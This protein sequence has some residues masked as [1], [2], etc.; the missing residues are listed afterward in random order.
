[1][2]LQLSFILTHIWIIPAL[3]LCAFLINVLFFR[4]SFKKFSGITALLFVGISACLSLLV[5]YDFYALRIN[6]VERLSFVPLEYKWLSYHPNMVAKMGII[7][8]P[9]SVMMLVVVTSISFLVHLFSLG[10]MKDDE[11]Y[12]RYFTYLPFF[13]FNM[14]GLILA[15]NIIQMFVFWELVG[16]SSFLL[17]GY[18]Y[19][20][21]SAVYA[22]KKAFIVTRF[23]DLGFLL[24]IL[25]LS[26]LGM[27][28][29]ILLNQSTLDQ[30]VSVFDFG[31]I[32]SSEFHSLFNSL[33]SGFFGVSELGFALILIFIGAAGKSAM[34]PLHI[35]LPDAM[36]GPTP[37]SAL[38]HAATMVVA[39]VYLVAR[40]FPAFSAANEALDLVG[41][42]GAITS[43]F[44]AI[45]ACTQVDLKRVLA[46]STL[47][48]LGYLMMGLGMATVESSL[49]FTA[50]MFHLFTHAFFKAALF[51]C[52]GA[53]IHALHSNLIL[54]MGGLRKKMP[55]THFAFLIACL[56][57]AGIPPFSGFFS[58]DEIIAVAVHGHHHLFAFISYVVAGLTAF[59]MFRVY[60]ICFYGHAKSQAANNAH[61]A[62]ISM[63]LPLMILSF[64][65]MIIGFFPM[66]SFI[67]L[68]SGIHQSIDYKIAVPATLVA[69]AG[70]FLAYVFYIKGTNLPDRKFLSFGLISKLVKNK[71]YIDEAYLFVTKKI[72]FNIIASRIAWFDRHIIDRFMDILGQITIC[73]GSQ[74]SKMQTGFLQ[75]Y[76]NIYIFA[77]LGI[78]YLLISK[79][80]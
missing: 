70:I 23:A 50:S 44:A 62:S 16:L 14:L 32:N 72:F 53:M 56:S 71:F 19:K 4:N 69:L 15:P 7:V 67:G 1:M 28:S 10:Y 33:N 41:V 77:M 57:I 42:I 63:T 5:A 58:K 35:W 18:Y 34:F 48:Q 2:P 60:F 43:L 66:N 61:E 11:G 6:T 22:S 54:D 47:S 25:L 29:N 17:I 40:L 76:L 75:H 31:F 37:V 79:G 30:T 3:S 8:D 59:Y 80:L 73:L 20:K 74:F 65:T 78:F 52:A 49:G 27:N 51:L 68:K 45:I 13:T 24:G 38:I 9:I 46:F 21:P 26:Y 55:L 39:G 36:E 12:G 64:L